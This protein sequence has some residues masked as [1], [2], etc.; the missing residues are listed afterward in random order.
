MLAAAPIEPGLGA[1]LIGWTA[2]GESLV[3]TERTTTSSPAHHYFRKGKGKQPE[4]PMAE[5]MAMSEAG[6]KVLTMRAEE[7]GE[8]STYQT[9]E[10]ATLG[11]VHNVRTGAEEKY[12]V[13]VK[14]LTP[15]AKDVLK[16][17]FA[18][19]PDAAAWETYK[20]ANNPT[21]TKG[22]EGPGGTKASVLVAGEPTLQWSVEDEMTVQY[23]VKLGTDKSV[24][25]TT[26]QMEAMYTPNRSVEVVWGTSGKRALFIVTTAQAHTMRGDVGPSTKFVIV[27]APP[28]VEVLATTRLKAEADRIAGVVEK[29]GF[30]V[31]LVGPAQKERPA[32]VIYADAAHQEMA[33]KLAAAIPGAT[34]DK[35][36][37]K[38][39]SELVVAVGAPTK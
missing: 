37:W 28:R 35:L 7:E 29:T 22:L 2:D 21:A 10:E 32:T 25:S 34:V 20:K 6:R 9:D 4:V 1:Q 39:N 31:T 24:I 36:S 14:A 38:A 27:P 11:V 23:V 15:Q 17:K 33:A 19:L 16:N 5:V 13:A 26:D 18:K 8:G 30:A 12:L 3:W